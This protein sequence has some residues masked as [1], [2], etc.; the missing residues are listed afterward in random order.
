MRTA[1]LHWLAGLLEG[2]GTFLAPPP[3]SPGCPAIR[4]EMCDRDVVARAATLF[5]RAV[6]AIVR[7]RPGRRP[8]FATAIKGRPAMDLMFRLAPLLSRS[9][10]A[11]IRRAVCT[12]VQTPLPD[13]AVE[14]TVEWVAGLL[15][16]EGSFLR[17]SR[18]GWVRISLEMC[19][20]ETVSRAAAA[21]GANGISRSDR[22]AERAWRSTYIASLN[23]NQALPWMRALRPLMGRRRRCAIDRALASWSPV[24]LVPAPRGC[25]VPDCD[26]SHRSRGLCHTHYMRWSRYRA[27]GKDP[28]FTTLR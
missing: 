2:E 23:G 3:S 4:L 7:E 26:R 12:I 27:A 20:R 9:R 28:G 16:G 6:C 15:E 10:R 8:S 25:V 19:D 14:P 11:Q 21:L 18:G 22:G 1:D 5:E 13:R 24:R 17:K